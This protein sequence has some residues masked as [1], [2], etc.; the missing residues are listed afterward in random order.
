MA[1]GDDDYVA[2]G[3]AL[4]VLRRRAGLTQAQAGERVQV[5]NTHI[6]SIE[7]GERGASYGLLVSLLRVYGSSLAEL[8]R[9][10]ERG[11]V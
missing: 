1:G 5:R 11:E 9:E 6:S 8:A 7:R 10:I 3:S 2:L 4:R